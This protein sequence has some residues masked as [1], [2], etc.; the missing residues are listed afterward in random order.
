MNNAKQFLWAKSSPYMSLWT[1]SFCVGTCMDVFLSAKSSGRILSCFTEQFC[2]DAEKTKHL[3]CYLSS[4]H[5]IGK[6]HPSFQAKDKTCYQRLKESMADDITQKQAEN[7]SSSFRHE[8]YSAEVLNRIW[9][10]K[11][12]PISV[13][14]PLSTIISLHHQKPKPGY[15]PSPR[16]KLWNTMQDDLEREMDAAFLRGTPLTVPQH[17][18]AVC[19]LISSII[20]LMDWVASSELFSLA[21]GMNIHEIRKKAENVLNLYGLISDQLFPVAPSFMDMFPQI[22]N[23]R[24]LQA[25]CSNISDK[26]RITIIEAPMGEGKTEAAL[27]VAARICN[28]TSGR[29][30]YMAL[31]SQA[32]SNQIY[33]RMHDVLSNLN[34]GDARLLHGTAFLINPLPNNYATEDEAIAAEWTRPARTGFLGANAVGTVDQAMASVLR[35]RFSM[36]RLAGLSNKVLIIDEI[37]AYDLYMSQ[38]IETLL[39]WCNDLNIP[40]ILLSATM[41]MEQKLRYLEC[42]GMTD[43]QQ[44]NA[45]YPLIT[46]VLQNGEL[47]QSHVESS[48]T[49]QYIFRPLTME[50][51]AETIANIAVNAIKNGGCLAIMM[52]TVAH[53]QEVF[54][55]IQKRAENDM[56]V[57]LFH[58]RFILSRRTE[59]EEECVS[60]FGKNRKKRPYKGILVATQVV[61]QS[62]DLDFDGMISELAPIDLLL[63]RAGR[64]HRHRENIRPDHFH[65]PVINVLLPTD[66]VKGELNQRY[67]PSGYVYDPF[68]LWNTEQHLKEERTVNVPGDIR[69]TIEKVY[70][71]VTEE[72]KEAWLRRSLRGILETTKAKGCTWPAPDPDLFFPAETNVFYDVTDPDDGFEMASEASTRLGDSGLR[73]AFCDEDA[74]DRYKMQGIPPEEQINV[75]LSSVQIRLQKT[76]VA[77]SPNA[78][79]IEKGKLAGVWLLRGCTEVD[80]ENCKIVNDPWLGVQWG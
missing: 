25:A 59:I 32:T 13:R 5:D 42:F 52:N 4:V 60:L 30:I 40:V 79:L 71:I 44:V 23:P 64:L 15:Q 62:I 77:G 80:L 46:Q 27:Y 50:Y 6:I 69:S 3:I 2:M 24:P 7:I 37:H 14:L 65:D 8:Y 18:D 47:I 74:F 26:A 39:R 12:Y 61:E 41:Q 53:A 19:M 20:I 67:G 49:Y 75:Y 22:K 73:I 1:H 43:H 57:K 55:A 29:G 63:Q 35:S 10:S 54:C 58:S 48:T 17:V 78:F 68:L 31:P 51:N 33:T 36:I 21:E 70:S 11:G 76:A 72:N 16:N 38:I 56:T 9:K 45:G 66:G 34:Y 28:S